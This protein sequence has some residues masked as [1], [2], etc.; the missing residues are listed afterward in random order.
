MNGLDLFSNNASLLA[1]TL[2]IPL[3]GAL[4]LSLFGQ[5]PNQREAISLTTSTML[6]L[7]IL[8]LAEVLWNGGRPY[9]ALVEMLPGMSFALTL[10]PLSLIFALTTSALWL[11]TTWYSI[12]Y[13]RKTKENHQTRFF[14]CFALAIACTM[15]VA[16]AANVFTLFICYELL[17]LSTYPL[18]THHKNAE[19]LRSGKHY[20]LTLLG[21]STLFFLPAM[22]ITWYYAG[23]LSFAQ[24]GIFPPSTPPVI[25]G[26]L[27]ALYLYGIAKAALMPLH[28]WLPN[29]MVAPVPVSALLHAVAVVK[30]GVFSIIMVFFY[31][32]GFGPLQA[33]ALQHPIAGLWPQYA[34]SFTI[35]AAALVAVREDNI[36]LRLAYS[37]I[38][39][40]GYIILGTVLLAPL[41]LIGAAVHLV[42][43]AL[44]KIT[45]FFAAGNI[46][47]VSKKTKVSELAGIGRAM[48]WTM[49]AFT[50][51]SLSLIGIP[52][53]LG[54]ISKW[55]LLIG[56]TH[57]QHYVA[58]AVIIMGTLLNAAY[59]LPI[60]YAA[61][62]KMPGMRP[63]HEDAP[64][65]MRIPL[66]LTSMA[67]V[68]LFFESDWLLQM[69][70][71]MFSMRE[72]T[73]LP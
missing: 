27:I 52:P 24:N 22:A 25:F 41:S 47:S 12:G 11:A 4:L 51:A 55:Y 50:I 18:V 23:T 10:R 16:F 1:L 38:S 34:A 32:L 65:R 63:T 40:L 60:L 21:S 7:V 67:C 59:L 31:V 5:N 14:A 72:A 66:V 39:H 26:M 46:Y 44:A 2:F 19:S 6:L 3:L 56:A 43:H 69:L 15:G 17:T 48:P 9:I 42:A 54:F 45:L 20:L 30:A 62:F 36:K 8:Q 29:A 28:R 49:G 35:I 13:L 57:E 70:G 73:Y 53:T 68:V 71:E 64:L 58:V 37:T 33:F 61:F